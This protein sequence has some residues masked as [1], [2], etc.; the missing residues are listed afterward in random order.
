MLP[1][2]VHKASLVEGSLWPQWK[3]IS[4]KSG[5]SPELPVSTTR[6]PDS[7]A[8]RFLDAEKLEEKGTPSMTKENSAWILH[9]Q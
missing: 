8:S 6:L 5:G 2:P 7:F 4:Q 1:P 3:Q 9:K